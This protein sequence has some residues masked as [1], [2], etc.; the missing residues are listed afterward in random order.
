MTFQVDTFYLSNYFLIVKMKDTEESICQQ[1]PS[2]SK[3]NINAMNKTANDY[4]AD[5]S[6]PL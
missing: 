5:F 3:R 6:I 1:I 4:V 2:E